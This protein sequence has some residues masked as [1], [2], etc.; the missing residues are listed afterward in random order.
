[1]VYVLLPTYFLFMYLNTYILFIF[2]RGQSTHKE[3][4]FRKWY[5]NIVE[6]K[7]LLRSSTQF[8]VFTATAT[9]T[10]KKTIYQ[11]LNLNA[12][13]TFVIE[14]PPPRGNIGDF[15]LRNRSFIT[16]PLINYLVR[17]EEAWNLISTRSKPIGFSYFAVYFRKTVVFSDYKQR[18]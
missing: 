1:M 13:N 14:K 16:S 17:G 9:K 5:A 2:C 11:M 15:F 3:G 4:P 10:T 18:D 8:A 6:L 12:I 7:S